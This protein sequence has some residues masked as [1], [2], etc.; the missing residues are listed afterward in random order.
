[1]GNCSVEFAPV[2]DVD[3][4]RLIGAHPGRVIRAGN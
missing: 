3:H 1:M 2:H 4:E